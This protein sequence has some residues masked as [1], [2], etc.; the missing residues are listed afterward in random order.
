MKLNQEQVQTREDFKKEQKG[1][2]ENQTNNTEEAAPQYKRV[3]IRLFPIWLRLLLLVV[4]MFICLMS[5]AAVGYGVIGSGKV[6]DIFKESTW[7]H[8]VDLVEKK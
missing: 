6:V 1:I 2:E 3:R 5:G 7:T 8:I 4:L